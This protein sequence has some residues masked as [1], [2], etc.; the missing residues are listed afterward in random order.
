MH[1]KKQTWGFVLLSLMLVGCSAKTPVTTAKQEPVIEE[2]TY[3]ASMADSID[4]AVLIDVNEAKKELYLQNVETGKTY[5][6]SYTGATTIQDKNGT[7]LVIWISAIP[8]VS[9][10]PCTM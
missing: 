10:M 1:M 4:E 8:T 2:S 6:L 7:E 5:R 3:D 9:S